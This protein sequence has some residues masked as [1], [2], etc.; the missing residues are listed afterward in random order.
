MAGIVFKNNQ[1]TDMYCPNCGPSVKLIVK[2]NRHN[3]NQFLGCPNWPECNYTN[4]IPEDWKMRALGQAELFD[5]V[6]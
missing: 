6:K 1:E 4:P 2:T 5:G 3:H